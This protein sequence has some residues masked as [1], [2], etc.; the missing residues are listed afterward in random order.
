MGSKGYTLVETLV[1]LAIIAIITAIAI[2]SLYTWSQ[3][4]RYKEAA[5]GILGDFRTGKQ[6]SMSTNLEHRVELDFAQKKYRVARGDRPSGS[7]TWTAVKAWTQMPGSVTLASGQLCDGNASI[8]VI[9][10]PN[11]SAETAVICVKDNATTKYRIGV[12]ATS[13]RASIS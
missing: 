12:N 3:S 9:F 1:A 5:W 4:L 11:G 13:G 6:L 8:N 7:T 10:K 2:P